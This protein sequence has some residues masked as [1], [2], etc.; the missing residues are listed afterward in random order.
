MWKVSMFQLQELVRLHRMGVTCHEVARLLGMSPNTERPYRE[1][2]DKA[3]LLEGP[4]DVLPDEAA[5]MDALRKH[6]GSGKAPEQPSSVAPWLDRIESWLD[7][8]AQP[9]AIH[10]RL[11]RE[12]D[13]YTGSLSAVKRACLRIRRLRGVRA[14]DVA[15]P[16]QTQPG[17]VAQ[18]D[19][20]YVGKLLD[21]RTMTMRKAW[22]FVMVLGH[23]RH[24][25]C[26]LSFDQKV[27]TW[28]ALHVRAFQWF[29]GVPAVL[30]PD[31]LKAAVIRAAFTADDTAAINRS[32]R[33][34]ARH[35]GF[36]I[37]PAPPYE[38][39][40]KGKVESAVKYVK[41]SFFSVY[42]GQ[43]DAEELRVR[44]QEWVLQTAGQRV[45]GTTFKR[46]L[47]VFEA[48]E[49]A[50]LQAL[51]AV[52]FTPVV[53]KEVKVHTDTHVLF[54]RAL[55]SVP[56]RWVGAKGWV[57]ATGKSV[58]IYMD[59]VRVAT[60]RRGHPGDRVTLEEHL[61]EGRRELRHR[62]REY[63]L[64]R[65]DRV[66]P[67]TGAFIREV[68]DADDVLDQLRKVQA[69]V[70]HLE[71]FPEHRAEGAAKRARFYANYEYRAIK[72]IL[73]DG[74]DRRPLPVATVVRDGRWPA[75][76]AT[77]RC[78]CRPRAGRCGG[79]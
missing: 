59:E 44:L 65:A 52:P 4:V 45:H 38:P 6:R 47:E 22:V 1:A 73:I 63:W 32:Y 51:P 49:R 55:Y 21:P 14:E 37:D 31:N 54:D 58:Q 11:K 56:W 78:P 5:L 41:R 28:L 13:D 23:S 66:G 53:W 39:K 76:H 42:S 7:D 29:G 74:L 27:E 15:I 79:A 71:A 25:Y 3:G 16:V 50:A 64:Q 68:F 70:T 30:V 8:G 62:S 69:I 34:L 72:R 33:E 12:H 26:E 48:V 17:E 43:L 77:S 67:E 40:K 61:P 24:M 60:H 36:R 2:L 19:F 57:R 35:F 46:P 20:G 75:P 10:E 18:V 9:T